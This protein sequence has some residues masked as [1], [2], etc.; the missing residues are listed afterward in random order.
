MDQKLETNSDTVVTKTTETIKPTKSDTLSEA[1]KL[2]KRIF[3]GTLIFIVLT[4][5]IA[6][7]LNYTKNRIFKYDTLNAITYNHHNCTYLLALKNEIIIYDKDGG[8][9]ETLS[10]PS[11]AE[12]VDFAFFT[13]K[14]LHVGNKTQHWTLKYDITSESYGTEWVAHDCF[15]TIYTFIGVTKSLHN[16]VGLH[17]TDN[18]YKLCTKVINTDGT[19]EWCPTDTLPIPK[20]L[21]SILGLLYD[22]K[23]KQYVLLCKLLNSKKIHLY[24]YDP[25]NKHTKLLN[26]QYQDHSL[27]KIVHGL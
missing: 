1:A 2:D 23:L 13:A 12:S 6:L 16:I 24:T 5:V 27:L 18:V 22:D 17:K 3:V 10:I 4:A 14:G 7:T 11:S 9:V 25:V 21:D 26:A 15:D 19:I 8:K 20:N